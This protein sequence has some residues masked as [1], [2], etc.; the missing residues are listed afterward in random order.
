MPGRDRL[1]VSKGHAG[2]AVYATL[3]N[4]GYFDK[5]E[6]LTLNQGGTK[7][8]SHCDMNL[9]TGIDMTTGSLGQGMS[10]AV[11]AAIGS[12]LNKDGA[13]IYAIIGDGESQ[14]GQIWEAA[15]FAAQKK[16]YNLIVFTDNN[17]MQIDGNTADINK[18]EPVDKALGKL[19]LECHYRRR[20]RYCPDRGGNKGA[21]KR[22]RKTDDDYRQHYKGKG[23]PF[24]EAKDMPTTICPLPKRGRPEGDR[25]NQEGITMAEIRAVFVQKFKEMMMEDPK[26]VVVDADLAK[27]SGTW[28]LRAEFPDRTLDVGVAEQNMVGV[29]AGLSS[30]G[31]KPLCYDIQRLRNPQGL[32]PDSRVLRL[33]QA[34]CQDSGHR[35]RY[36]GRSLTAAPT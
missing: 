11:G 36:F 31:Y 13:Y 24:V 10:C 20:A 25:G 16:L 21:P 35:P 12:Q 28:S 29:A 14:E 7:L 23:V 17:G 4:R 8:P 18:V 3:A 6:L 1:I 27:A 19:R 2:P 22:K 26:V 32:R 30:Y 5:S 33:R 15:M 34:E 9:T